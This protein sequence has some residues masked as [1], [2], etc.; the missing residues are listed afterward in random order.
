MVKLI[1]VLFILI[2]LLSHSYVYEVHP[3]KHVFYYIIKM[4][5]LFFVSSK[6][7]YCLAISW[8]SID[9]SFY[10]EL[11]MRI[12]VN[13]NWAK[14]SFWLN[15]SAR[16]DQDGRIKKWFCQIE[17]SL[18]QFL[19]SFYHSVNLVLDNQ[20]S[21]SWHRSTLSTNIGQEIDCR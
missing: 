13:L 3:T 10:N 6:C 1:K 21:R 11:P 7:R 20:I 8:S 19:S 12:E 18:R 16:F 14:T 4:W 15:I 9:L 2:L 5:V 17:F